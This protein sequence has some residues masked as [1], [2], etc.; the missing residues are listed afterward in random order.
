MILKFYVKEKIGEK[1]SSDFWLETSYCTK[2]LLV[3]IINYQEP[4]INTNINNK[5][6]FEKYILILE[7]L[8]I[9]TTNNN[10]ITSTQSVNVLWLF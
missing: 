9:I 10:M 1:E 7:N 5:K 2:A 3:N 6:I 8:T 4:N